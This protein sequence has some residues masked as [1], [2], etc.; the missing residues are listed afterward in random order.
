M[1]STRQQIALLEA[2]LKILLQS[3][4]TEDIEQK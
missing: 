1:Q 2:K 4:K 3:E